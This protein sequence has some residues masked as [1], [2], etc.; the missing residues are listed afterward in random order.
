MRKRRFPAAIRYHKKKNVN[1]HQYFLSE[2]MLCYPFRDEEKDLHSNNEELC[3][4]LYL[5]E[6]D[7]I[8]KVKMQV[9][10]HLEN[11]EEARYM[12]EEYMKT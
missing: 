1:P 8:R 6:E 9:M 4:Q 7:N 3:A 12:V 11:I 2:L 10:E 5:R